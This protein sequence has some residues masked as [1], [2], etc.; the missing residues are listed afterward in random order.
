M[1]RQSSW[2]KFHLNTNCNG[3]LSD[4]LYD[5]VNRSL[6]LVRLR[7]LL[8]FVNMFSL[9]RNYLLLEKVVALHLNKLESPSPKDAL[10]QVLVEIDLVVLKKKMKLWTLYRQTDDRRSGKL[11]LSCCSGELKRIQT[12]R[13]TYTRRTTDE[14]GE[15]ISLLLERQMF[16]LPSIK[17]THSAQY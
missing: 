2:Y 13:R 16:P 17:R 4:P 15:L 11:T 9:F 3:E 5:N 14:K 6:T 7:R 10:C 8:N 1:Q 12:S